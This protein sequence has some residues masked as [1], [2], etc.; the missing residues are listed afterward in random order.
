MWRL[1]ALLGLLGSP[2]MADTIN[3]NQAGCASRQA[4]DEMRTAASNNDLRQIN[5][6]LNN[7]F[8]FAIGGRE[9]SMVELGLSVSK[10]RVYAGSESALLYVVTAATR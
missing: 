8:C 9:F 1:A 5:F 10:V 2:I 4:L 7:Q 3:A 6:L